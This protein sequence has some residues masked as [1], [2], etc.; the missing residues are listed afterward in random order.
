MIKEYPIVLWIYYSDCIKQ[1]E[2]MKSTKILET[3]TFFQLLT[4]N[5]REVAALMRNPDFGANFELFDLN[6]FC[7][8]AED[9]ARAFDR[10]QNHLNC[11]LDQEDISHETA[12]GK[13]RPNFT[14]SFGDSELPFFKCPS[15]LMI[16]TSAN[17]TMVFAWK[18]GDS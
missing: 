3:C 6:K 14:A 16:P 9:L 10:A 15:A 7:L 12:D 2:R 11:M 13:L 18:A 1:I 8:Y 17:M 4:K 5:H